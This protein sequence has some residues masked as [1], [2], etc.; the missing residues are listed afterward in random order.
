MI[1]SRKTYKQQND[2]VKIILKSTLN[3]NDK[4]FKIEEIFEEDIELTTEQLILVASV[5][6]EVNREIKVDFY[7]LWQQRSIWLSNR[8][9]KIIIQFIISQE[10]T[11][12]N[13]FEAIKHY[14]NHHGKVKSPPK[15]I[16]WLDDKQQDLLWEMNEDGEEIFQRRLYKMFLFQAINDGI[17]SGILNFNQSYRYRYLE[18]YLISKQEWKANKEQL[19]IDAE[20]THLTDHEGMMEDL[21]KQIDTFFHQVNDN[22]NLGI[23]PYLKFGKNNKPIITTPPV[24]KSDLTKLNTYYRHAHYVSILDL[25]ADVEKAAPFLHHFGHQSKIHE[26]KRPTAETFFASIIALGCNI[27]VEKMRNISKG[28]QV[29]TLQN[30]T[31]WYLSSQALQDVNNAI[32]KVKNDLDL[33]EIHRKNAHE[34][35]TA[36]DGQKF[37]VKDNSL[38]ASYSYKYPGYT[39]ASVV[40]TAVDERF[41]LFSSAVVT[42]SDRE[43]ISMVDMHLGNPVVKSTIHSTDTHGT[44]EV[45]FGIMYLLDIY[46]APRIKDIASLQLFGFINKQEYVDLDYELLP[47]KSINTSLIQEYWDEILRV[48]VSLK[49]GKTSAAQILKRLNSYAHQNPLH[50]ALKEFGKVTRTAFILKYYDDVELRQSVEKLLSHIEMMNR[51]AKAVFFG[52]NQEFQIATKE[53]QEKIVLC[54]LILQN[55]IVLWNYLYLSDLIIKVES[56]EELEDIVSSIRNG[57]AVAWEHINM[58]GEYDFSKLLNNKTLRFDMQKLMAMKYPKTA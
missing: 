10:N 20:M 24:E 22:Y 32:I 13:L 56:P 37:L 44:S 54:R 27:G 49:L 55:S 51:F 8:I 26:K 18:E 23:N 43:A 12:K 16:K 2:E 3:N 29:S 40:N 50:K 15:N 39:M 28:I 17:K 4:V 5:E 14:I 7:R 46:F 58:L 45:V 57:T 21:K 47:D 34:L 52:N 6:E 53:E 38:N 41:A 11:D 36:S 31:D 30:T 42:A 33:P 9:G 48:I 25:L 19:L 1:D 35:H